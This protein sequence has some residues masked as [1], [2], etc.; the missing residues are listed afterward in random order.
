M[1]EL[2]RVDPQGRLLL[3]SSWRKRIKSKEVIIVEDGDVLIV[4]PKDNPDLSKY[5]DFIHVEIPPEVYSDY[6]EL[7]KFL[8]SRSI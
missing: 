1:V 5:K 4:F 6:H 2:K 7:K 8:L 3:P